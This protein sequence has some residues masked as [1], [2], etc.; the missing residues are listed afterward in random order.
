MSWYDRLDLD[1]EQRQML[2]RSSEP[3]ELI[4]E[5]KWASE[6][7]AFQAASLHYNCPVLSLR[8]YQPDQ[9]TVSLLSEQQARRVRSVPLFRVG[10]RLYLAVSDPDNLQAQDF[11]AQL[12]GCII[13]PV[14]VLSKDIDEA[15]NRSMITAESSSQ[16]LEAMTAAVEGETRAVQQSA[17]IEDRD[18]PTVKM[19]DH[20]IMQAIRLGASDLHLEAFP[21]KILLRYRIDGQLREYPA[22]PKPVY[23]AVVSRIKITSSLD[24]AERRLPQDGRASIMVDDKKY[25]LRVSIIPN[26]HGEGIVIR[27]LNPHAVSMDLTALGFEKDILERYQRI[28]ARPH[29]VV[30]VTGPTGSGK[31]TTLYATLNQISGIAKKIIT[32]EDPV[33]YQLANITQIQIQPDIGYTYAQGLRAILRHDPDVVLVGEIRD[34]ESA[35]IAIRAALTGHQMFSTLHTNDAPQAVTRLLDMGIPF[36]QLQAALNGILAQRLVRR[37]CPRCRLPDQDAPDALLDL[38]LRPDQ[39]SYMAVGCPECN[40][41]GYR[42]RVAVHELLDFTPSLRRLRGDQINAEDIAHQAAS[43]GAFF[44]MADSLR[45]KVLAGTTSLNEALQLLHVE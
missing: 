15:L 40:N 17:V 44:T 28:L 4:L 6:N 11:V 33:E 21:H 26:V 37:L 23:A 25:D 35:Q 10:N 7:D 42:G 2:Q 39:G 36:Y 14:L 13:E 12:T 18:V 43:E 24:I 8:R 27:I 38:G 1:D 32:L 41:I 45:R 19:V 22:P 30:L 34:L 20:I 5:R 16:A 31:S 3:L 29:G 9:E